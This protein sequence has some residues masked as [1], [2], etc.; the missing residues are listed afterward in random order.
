MENDIEEPRLLVEE[1]PDQIADQVFPM[2]CAGWSTQVRMQ[3]AEE[4][5]SIELRAS[6]PVDGVDDALVTIAYERGRWGVDETSTGLLSPGGVV[7]ARDGRSVIE[8]MYGHVPAWL[9]H[10]AGAEFDRGVLDL[11]DRLA[12]E[13]D[14][15]LAGIVDRLG[16]VVEAMIWALEVGWEFAVTYREANA[17]IEMSTQVPPDHGDQFRLVVGEVLNVDVRDMRMRWTFRDKNWHLDSEA[18]GFLGADTNVDVAE[19]DVLYEVMA[20]A[21][22]NCALAPSDTSKQW[23][24]GGAATPPSTL[25]VSPPAQE[26]LPEPDVIDARALAIHA[27]AEANGFSVPLEPTPSALIRYLEQAGAGSGGYY[28]LEFTDGQCYIGESIDLPE[29][30]KQHRGCYRD[31]H[32]IRVSADSEATRS[33]HAKRHLRL[34]ERSLIH[35]AQEAGL[36]ARNINEMAAMIGVSKH[37]D[38]LISP[39][40]QRIWL[41]APDVAN[42]NDTTA[43]ERSSA[44]RLARTAANYRHFL[45]HPDA[46]RITRIIGS[47]LT[48]CVPYPARTEFHSWAVS[49]LTT[50]GKRS[51]RVSCL[52]IAM[53]EML[54]IYQDRGISGRGTIQ[55]NADELFPTDDS[56]WAFFRRHPTV[57]L[58]PAVYEESGPGQLLLCVDTLDALE[59]LL[60]DV[61]VTRAAATTALNIMRKGPCMQRKVHC[62]QLA[63]GAF[64]SGYAGNR[65]GN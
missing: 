45:T 51:G 53:T 64:D 52:T 62:P 44:E 13:D 35:S 42:A 50:P 21:A 60:D 5:T 47:Y 24:S 46:N 65:S 30:L 14:P 15:V 31:I 54:V 22:A 32:R 16:P 1:L 9:V 2:F 12:D 36:F 10:E 56:V 8:H 41:A 4:R 19:L 43:R 28:I 29:R 40:E 7:A 59:R 17:V 33:L 20:V 38:D 6:A 57:Q 48:R 39:D 37:L 25:P 23:H 18:T 34:R 27:W 11:H 26:L 49:C 58:S 55:V 63:G 3:A 61:A